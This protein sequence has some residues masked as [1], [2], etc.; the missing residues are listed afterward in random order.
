MGDWTV[1]IFVAAE[2]VL[3]AVEERQVL[4]EAVVVVQAS[5]KE[6]FAVARR[7]PP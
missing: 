5:L 2:V 4:E 6:V 3:L 7:N 1:T